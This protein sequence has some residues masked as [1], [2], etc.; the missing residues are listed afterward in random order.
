MSG[1]GPHQ[2]ETQPADQGEPV[3]FP[4]GCPSCHEPATL[5]VVD[6]KQE[7]VPTLNGRIAPAWYT[8]PQCQTK[9]QVRRHLDRLTKKHQYHWTCTY[10]DGSYGT[11][12]Y[13]DCD[14]CGGILTTFEEFFRERTVYKCLR[15]GHLWVH[16]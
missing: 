13:Q 4:Y 10:G 2:S 7:G 6:D 15:C 14:E 1:N 12:G 3:F 16:D 8:C 11:W 9:W 5:D